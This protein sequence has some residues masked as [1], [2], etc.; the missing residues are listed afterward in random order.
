[1]ATNYYKP[2]PIKLTHTE[3]IV[4]PEGIEVEFYYNCEVDFSNEDC[5][6]TAVCTG[7]QVFKDGAKVCKWEN[8][9]GLWKMVKRFHDWD[10]FEARVIERASYQHEFNKAA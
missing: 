8:V 4:F 1:M 9:P 2:E 7:D 3:H 6:V 10:G 5:P